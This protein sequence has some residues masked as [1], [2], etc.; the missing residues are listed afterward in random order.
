MQY[1]NNTQL[2]VKSL[3]LFLMVCMQIKKRNFTTK[4]IVYSGPILKVLYKEIKCNRIYGS[5][6]HAHTLS[7]KKKSLLNINSFCVHLDT[8]KYQTFKMC[9]KP[10]F[11]IQ[12]TIYSLTRTNYDAENHTSDEHHLVKLL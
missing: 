11:Y 10:Y 1:Y 12:S 5:C 6:I 4:Y 3:K 2:H 7:K 9:Y 8:S